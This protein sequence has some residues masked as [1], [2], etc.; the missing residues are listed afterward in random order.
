MNILNDEECVWH[1]RDF[2]ERLHPLDEDID[3]TSILTIKFS[4]VTELSDAFADH[5]QHLHVT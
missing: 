1:L 2:N 5:F 3:T 4:D